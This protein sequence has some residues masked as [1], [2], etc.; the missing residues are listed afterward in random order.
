M[1]RLISFAAIYLY[2]LIGKGAASVVKTR[3]WKYLQPLYNNHLRVLY[4]R[5]A[6]WAGT[7]N[8]RNINP[9]Y[10]P[11]CPKIPH[12][13]CQTPSLPLGS[14]A[15][16]NRGKTAERNEEPKDKNPHLFYTCIILHL[17]RSLVNHWSSLTHTSHCMTTSWP[18]AA[19][20]MRIRVSQAIQFLR[21]FYARCSSCHNPPNF[22]AWG[23]AQNMLACITWG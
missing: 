21:Y 20:Q 16:K 19:T 2:H 4:P 11:H 23:P 8:L 3:S 6:R 14:N 5:Q 1:N 12:K 15:K 17:M 22:W 10:H 18:A 9:I 7:K 13:H